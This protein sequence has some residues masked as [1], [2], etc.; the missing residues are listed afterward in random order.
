V[1]DPTGSF[2]R[3][4]STGGVRQVPEERKV[5]GE[6]KRFALYQPNEERQGGKTERDADYEVSYRSGGGI[7]IAALAMAGAQESS[8]EYPGGDY[9]KTAQAAFDHLERNNS[10]LT[11]DGRDNI[12]DDY[13]ALAAATELF[14][15]THR[16]AYKAAAD[17]RARSLMARLVTGADG[18]TYWRAD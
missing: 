12:V 6:M 11:N 14:R 4:V 13:C 16:D 15:A 3:S 7:A 9:L 2:Y 8:G 17:R 1:K 5:A 10:A 18:R